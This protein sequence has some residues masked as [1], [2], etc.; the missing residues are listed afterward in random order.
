MHKKGITFIFL[1]LLFL[2]TGCFEIVEEVSFNK[3]GSG[4]ITLTLNLSKSKYPK[5]H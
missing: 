3:D 5:S 1:G 2:C 4:H